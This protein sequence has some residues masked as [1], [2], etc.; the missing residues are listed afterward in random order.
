[1]T[2]HHVRPDGSVGRCD[3]KGGGRCKFAREGALHFESAGEAQ[4]Y[5]AELLAHRSNGFTQGVSA[6]AVDSASGEAGSVS[7]GNSDVTLIAERDTRMSPEESSAHLARLERDPGVWERVVSSPDAMGGELIAVADGALEAGGRENLL[8]A[9]RALHHPN[10]IPATRRYVA[11]HPDL[12]DEALSDPGFYGWSDEDVRD[13]FEV[14]RELRLS[15]AEK[16]QRVKD[17]FYERDMRGLYP[18][19]RNESPRMYDAPTSNAGDYRLRG[20]VRPEPLRSVGRSRSSSDDE[21]IREAAERVMG[22]G[23]GE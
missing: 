6:S 18:T 17:A 2:R 16:R 23:A 10:M 11:T 22:G 1:M 19:P 21:L 8:L 5:A 4:E 12:W 13:V 14:S 9:V 20:F 3:A 15:D 7:S